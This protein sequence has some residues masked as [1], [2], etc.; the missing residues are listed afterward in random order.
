MGGLS[1]WLSI[2][3]DHESWLCNIKQQLAIPMLYKTAELAMEYGV[4]NTERENTSTV[5][6]K[7]QLKERQ[8]MYHETY[9]D[10]MK[11]ALAAIVLPSDSDCFVC[12]RRNRVTVAI[13]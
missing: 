10:K 3:C 6:D 11:K 12:K 9:N 2:E 7:G 13:P 1:V 5:R 4:F 8:L